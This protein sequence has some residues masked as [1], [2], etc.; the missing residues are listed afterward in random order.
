MPDR[1]INQSAVIYADLPSASGTVTATVTSPVGT[2]V[3]GSPFTA[4]GHDDARY[5]F[6]IASG[7]FTRSGVYTV[8]W[9]WGGGSKTTY[10]TGGTELTGLSLWDLRL[11]VAGR[12]GNVV[13]GI[14]TNAVANAVTDLD[15]IGGPQNYRNRW[16]MLHP[17]AGT[18]LMAK[19]RRVKDYSG[20]ALVLSSPFSS[21]PPPTTRYALVIPDP[22]D[23]DRAIRIAFDEME[24]RVRTPVLMT[25]LALA[26]G[27]KQ[28][29]LE[30][31]L[32]SELVRIDDV[33]VDTAATSNN[34]KSGKILDT[35][36]WWLEPGRKLVVYVPGDELVAADTL[37][38]RGSRR[39]FTPQFDDSILDVES[40][41]VAAKAAL[42][43]LATQATGP[44][45][46]AKDHMRRMLVMRQEYAETLRFSVGRV[47]N[48][49]RIVIA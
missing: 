11:M 16:L 19:A 45:I 17:D 40:T 26:A 20:S 48:G 8:A 34:L 25:G 28:D 38:I 31:I 18:A 13:E 14:V 4:T 2:A 22:K 43:L 44:A 37:R 21:A 12:F 49:S 33:W 32:P 9:S 29:T 15:L 23:I 7:N 10:F 24:D 41:A 5:S 30:L 35:K 46:D 47:P 3:T 6:T 36:L 42:E 39:I 1:T 27:T